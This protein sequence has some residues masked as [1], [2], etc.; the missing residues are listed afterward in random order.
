MGRAD[1]LRPG[2]LVGAIAGECDIPGTAIGAILIK[3]NFSFLDID[4]GLAPDV[5]RKMAKVKIR[6]RLARMRAAE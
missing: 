3:D 6:G 5:I 2:D 4:E 1:N